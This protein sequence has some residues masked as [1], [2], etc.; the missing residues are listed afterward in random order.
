MINI[1]QER[2]LDTFQTDL[3][4]RLFSWC[5]WKEW[6]FGK[7]RLY[8]GLKAVVFNYQLLPL[9]CIHPSSGSVNLVVSNLLKHGSLHVTHHFSTRNLS[10]NYLTEMKKRTSD[11]RTNPRGG[12]IFSLE[13]NQPPWLPHQRWQ[14]VLCAR[15]RVTR[16]LPASHTPGKPGASSPAANQVISETLHERPQLSHT[17]PQNAD[18]YI[19]R[20]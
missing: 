15:L 2:I 19:R 12:C 3:E 9:Q 17:V 7:V 6:V 18:T 10:D 5:I 13:Q 4:S 11:S 20:K 1:Q 14:L 16:P 8:F